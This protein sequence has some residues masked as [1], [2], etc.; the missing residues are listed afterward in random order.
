M[1]VRREGNNEVLECNFKKGEKAAKQG[2][3]GVT[4]LKSEVLNVPG[5][6]TY[7]EIGKGTR[8]RGKASE[9]YDETVKDLGTDAKDINFAFVTSRVFPRTKQTNKKYGQRFYEGTKEDW[10]RAR[11]KE[12]YFRDVR[13]ID[14]EVLVSWTNCHPAIAALVAGTFGQTI[15]LNGF[16]LPENVSRKYVDRFESDKIGPEILILGRVETASFIGKDFTGFDIRRL[17][18]ANLEEAIAFACFAYCGQPDQQKRKTKTLV[19]QNSETIKRFEHYEG[20]TFI[21]PADLEREI[22]T[23]KQKNNIIICSAITWE[24][25]AD[26]HS[27]RIPGSDML[28]EYLKDA[29]FKDHRTLA[30]MAGGSPSSLA[31]ILSKTRSILPEYEDYPESKKDSLL[32]AMLLGGWDTEER[33]FNKKSHE[34]PD[35]SLISDALSKGTYNDFEEALEETTDNVDGNKKDSLLKRKGDMFWVKAPVDAID[36][37]LPHMKDRHFDW[38]QKLLIDTFSGKFEKSPGQDDPFEHG[39]RHSENLKKGVAL[40][41]CILANR[42]VQTGKK[43]KNKPLKTWAEDTFNK[44]TKEVDFATFIASRDGLLRLFAEA[45]PSGFIKALKNTLQGNPDGLTEIMTLRKSEF[46]FW[47][48]NNAVNILWSLERLAWIPE[49]FDDV[50]NI[51]VQMHKLDPDKESNSHPRP[52]SVFYAINVGFSPQTSVTSIDRL[53]SLRKLANQHPD[54]VFP[55]ILKVLPS[56]QGSVGSTSK[57]LFYSAQQPKQTWEQFYDYN[58]GLFDIGIDLAGS[59]AEKISQIIETIHLY[60]EDKCDAVLEKWGHLSGLMSEGER[61][62]IWQASR[63][64]Y[65][66][67]A[68]YPDTDWSMGIERCEKL[69]RFYDHFEPSKEKLVE[70]LFSETYP[71][72]FLEDDDFSGTKL[73]ELRLQYINDIIASEGL[74]KVVGLR[75][76]VKEPG[77]LG[78]SIGEAIQNPD[79]A[80]EIIQTIGDDYEY[81]VRGVSISQYDKDEKVWI[82]KLISHIKIHPTSTSLFEALTAL[83]VDQLISTTLEDSSL[84]KKITNRFWRE[85]VINTW[86]TKNLTEQIIE[87]LF[88]A[89]RHADIIAAMRFNIDSLPD[90]TL[91]TLARGF[92]ESIENKNS[93]EISGSHLDALMKLLG[94]IREKKLMTVSEL[95]ILEYPLATQFRFGH[96]KYPFAIF[97]LATEDAEQFVE[98][99]SYQ[100]V[101]E[102]RS[103]LDRNWSEDAIKFRAKNSFHVINNIKHPKLQLGQ[104]IPEQELLAWVENVKEQ[105]EQYGLVDKSL[106]Y[107]GELLSQCSIDHDDA[108]WPRREVRYVIEKMQSERL[109]NGFAIRSYNERGTFS[110]GYSHYNSY[111][112]RYKGWSE[113][114][115]QWPRTQALLNE[116]ERRDRRHAEES[117]LRDEQRNERNW[118]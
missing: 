104:S 70:L 46:W 63:K 44:L 51:L 116:M 99:I 19:I 9:E 80:L 37:L 16:E 85:V 61:Q 1:L 78:L 18:A 10:L 15:D 94:L 118:L 20:C 33:Y 113:N 86:T 22:Q 53:T 115:D 97:E 98:I 57:P 26:K 4:K 34:N 58:D 28:A 49:Y 11:K 25:I 111:A 71:Q 69:R 27:L 12:G 73:K 3:D 41:F 66:H 72:Y 105:A 47:D 35:V 7:W 36:N 102:K 59:N 52:S 45:V 101:S 77:S 31:R 114:M 67:H 83:S 60:S 112:D 90:S 74:K 117:K 55:L 89:E 88:E 38:F 5:G 79:E 68:K 84:P 56:S 6:E 75:L 14:Q 95:A 62:K 100:F 23:I 50:L 24:N 64:L 92:Y 54:D 103:E 81:F 109:E 2:Y 8:V 107:V 30:M 32:N 96:N 93:E 48:E 76:S 17:A 21:I 40:T 108:L 91:V 65:V 13:V 43:Y 39:L 87:R 29:G 106:Y 42:G 110:D 82:D